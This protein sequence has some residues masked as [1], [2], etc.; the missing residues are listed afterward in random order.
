MLIA[1]AYSVDCYYR[2]ELDVLM[3]LGYLAAVLN[4]WSV[5]EHTASIRAVKALVMP[6]GENTWI[7]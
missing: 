3:W 1:T 4:G 7:P 6:A 5:V 2:Q